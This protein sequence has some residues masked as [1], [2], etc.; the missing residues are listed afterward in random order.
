M[1]HMK[2]LA[3]IHYLKSRSDALA[4]MIRN[5]ELT[6]KQA[7]LAYNHV[8]SLKYRLPST[9]LSYKQITVIHR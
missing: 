8:A 4:N 9:S 5:Y 1:N 2:K 7:T 6:H 3:E